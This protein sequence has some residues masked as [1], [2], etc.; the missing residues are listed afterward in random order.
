MY[1]EM[2]I[3]KLVS[4]MI[5]RK[6]S[7]RNNETIDSDTP[8]TYIYGLFTTGWE[9]SDL[10]T[11]DDFAVYNLLDDHMKTINRFGV[12]KVSDVFLPND[13]M[14]KSVRFVMDYLK[15]G[16]I[17]ESEANGKEPSVDDLAQFELGR[18]DFEKYY[19][20]L[21]DESGMVELYQDLKK[22]QANE[23]VRLNIQKAGLVFSENPIEDGDS[24]QDYMSQFGMDMFISD[25]AEVSQPPE[26]LK[27]RN[28]GEIWKA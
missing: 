4:N 18:V 3:V 8:V 1:D 12:K 14:Y 13:A 5:Q 25:A 10:L 20:D 19:E 27:Y 22:F 16:Y 2:D 23:K 7:K 9:F 15:E 21:Y 6:E 17:E 24:A 28:C 26:L 11:N